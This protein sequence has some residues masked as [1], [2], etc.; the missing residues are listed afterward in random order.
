M[1]GLVV[2][3]GPVREILRSRRRAGRRRT[4][5]RGRGGRPPAPVVPLR[6]DAGGEIIGR[7]KVTDGD[8]LRIAGHEIRLFGIDAPEM[9]HPF[10]PEAKWALIYLCKG[11][12]VRA[13]I[14]ERDPHGRIVAK[15]FLPDGRDLSAELVR[16]GLAL[17]WRKHS[18]GAYRGLEVP[19]VREKLWLADARQRGRMDLWR[20]H[21]AR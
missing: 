20:A 21:D 15:C 9:K 18:G 13:E 16:Q 11:Q 3:V 8:G 2:L 7:A 4:G 19:G 10:G 14:V 12:T 1:L 6:I 5:Q 17:D